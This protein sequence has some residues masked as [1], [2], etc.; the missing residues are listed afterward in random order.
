MTVE[1]DETTPPTATIS[2]TA[3]LAES[4]TKT[5]PLSSTA[6]PPRRLKA[7]PDRDSASGVRG[8]PGCPAVRQATANTAKQAKRNES[9]RVLRKVV[10]KG[11]TE[12]VR[13]RLSGTVMWKRSL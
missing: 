4:A 3:W 7:A 5:F 8:H 10:R 9:L 6:T 11:E 2:L 13:T 12:E 1:V